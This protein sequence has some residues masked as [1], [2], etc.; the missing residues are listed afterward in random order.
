MKLFQTFGTIIQINMESWSTFIGWFIILMIY[1]WIHPLQ[2]SN[3][4]QGVEFMC[5]KSVTGNR[6]GKLFA[7]ALCIQ[8][9]GTFP[10]GNLAAASRILVTVILPL[11]ITLKLIQWDDV[12][13]PVYKCTRN[14]HGTQCDKTT[15]PFC[16]SG[17]TSSFLQMEVQITV[18]FT[19][20]PYI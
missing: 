8:S 10:T 15:S 4:Y 20:L 12:C 16:F 5:E 9:L 11:T 17:D 13:T 6:K 3:M 7:F 14:S 1:F 18:N 19:L 2:N